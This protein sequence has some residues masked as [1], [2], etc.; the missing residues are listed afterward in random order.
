LKFCPK[1]KKRGLLQLP[2]QLD[3]EMAIDKIKRRLNKMI[4]KNI[5]GIP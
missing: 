3:E 2:Q 4:V 5:D 1:L